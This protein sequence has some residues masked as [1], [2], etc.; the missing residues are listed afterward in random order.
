MAEQDLQDILELKAQR[1]IAEKE[2]RAFGLPE[3]AIRETLEEFYNIEELT[4]D[5]MFEDDF[6]KDDDF[7]NQESYTEAVSEKISHGIDREE[8][9]LQSNMEAIKA[10]GLQFAFDFASLEKTYRDNLE[11]HDLEEAQLSS[12]W[13]KLKRVADGL[14]MNRPVQTQE[15]N[16]DSLTLAESQQPPYLGILDPNPSKSLPIRKKLIRTQLKRIKADVKRKQALMDRANE[17]QAAARKVVRELFGDDLASRRAKR[18]ESN[19]RAMAIDAQELEEKLQKVQEM[20]ETSIAGWEPSRTLDQ[21]VRDLGIYVSQE[22]YDILPEE[23]IKEFGLVPMD[24][25]LLQDILDESTGSRK[26]VNPD[27]LPDG[28][29]VLAENKKGSVIPGVGLESQTIEDL[30]LTSLNL[31]IPVTPQDYKEK[32]LSAD[33]NIPRTSDEALDPEVISPFTEYYYKK[34][35]SVEKLFEHLNNTLKEDTKNGKKLNLAGVDFMRDLELLNSV[36]L[37]IE[38]ALSEYDASIGTIIND[39]FNAKYQASISYD[40][41]YNFAGVVLLSYDGPISKR[42][43]KR[44]PQIVTNL[45]LDE[46][47]FETDSALRNKNVLRYLQKFSLLEQAG[48]DNASQELNS[49]SSECFNSSLT[50][51]GKKLVSPLVEYLNFSKMFQEP[52]ISEPSSTELEKKKQRQDHVQ[53]VSGFKA[54]IENT[55]DKIN[56]AGFKA[57]RN[58][59]KGFSET[60]DSVNFGSMSEFDKK[61]TDAWM[62]F[63]KDIKFGGILEDGISQEDMLEFWTTAIYNPLLLKICP[64]EL[65]QRILECLMPSDCREIIKYIGIWRTRE[66]LENIAYLDVFDDRNGL[67]EALVKWDKLVAQKYNFKAV[68]FDGG[69]GLRSNHFDGKE[70][71]PSPSRMAVSLLVRTDL[72]HYLANE[73][74]K[75][76]IIT[77]TDTFAI[78]KSK[79]EELVFQITSPSG[80]IVEY[81]T[82]G[83]KMGTDN[84]VWDFLWHQIGFQWNGDAGLLTAYIDGVAVPTELTRGTPFMG[85]LNITETNSEFVIASSDAESANKSFAAQ[86]DE[87]VVFSKTLSQEQWLKLADITSDVNLNTMGMSDQTTDT[88]IWWRMGDSF[89]DTLKSNE[90]GGKI[91]D[92]ISGINLTKIP[93]NEE[94]SRVVV[95]RTVKQ[96]DEDDF[97]DI[98]ARDTDLLRL[99][100]LLY[101]S[102]AELLNTGFNVDEMIEKLQTRFQLPDFTKDPHQEVKIVIEKAVVFNLLKVVADYALAMIEKYLMDC[103]NWKELFKAMTKSTFNGTLAP[104]AESSAPLAQLLTSFD[105]PNFWSEFAQ[106]G[107]PFLQDATDALQQAV[108]ITS[109][110]GEGDD[111]KESAPVTLGIGSVSFQEEQTM[112]TELQDWSALGESSQITIQD[113]GRSDN[114]STAIEIIKKTSQNVS[115]AELLELLSSQGQESTVAKVSEI[116]NENFTD[117]TLS[118]SDIRTVFGI[119]GDALGV[120]GLIDQLAAAAENINIESDLPEEFCMPGQTFSDRVGFPTTRAD[121]QRNKDA[122]S[123]FLDKADNLKADL[124]NPCATPIP[125]SNFEQQALTNTIN[126]V[127]SSVTVAYDNDLLLYRLGMTSI[128]DKKEKIPKVL[129]KGEKIT[130]QVYDPDSGFSDREIEIKKTQINPDFEALIEQGILPLK[131][132]GTVDG[133]RFG[134]VVKINWN[135][136]DIFN[137]ETP[138]LSEKKPPE[139]LSP[140]VDGDNVKDPDV[141]IKDIGSSLGPYTDYEE[142]NATVSRPTAKLGG[143]MANSLSTDKL[144]FTLSDNE[145][146]TFYFSERSRLSERGYKDIVSKSKTSL[147]AAASKQEGGTDLSRDSFSTITHKVPYGK[148]LQG[149]KYVSFLKEG[150]DPFFFDDVPLEFNLS[151]NLQEEIKNR[152]YDDTEPACDPLDPTSDVELADSEKY[153]P[154][155]NVFAMVARQ[156]SSNLN[157]SDSVL[158][159]DAYNQLYREVLT[160]LLY[161][162]GDSPLLK[163]VPGTKDNTSE[164]LIG[165]NFLNI[166]VNP[167]LIDMQS[168]SEQVSNDFNQ[169]INCP[170]ALDEP[171]LYTALKTSV[172]RI[173]ARISVADMVLRGVIPFS[174]LF[175]SKRDPVIK[176]FIMKKLE[177]DIDLFADDVDGVKAK[178]VQ[179]YNKLAKTGE[180][181]DPAVSEDDYLETWKTAMNF[182]VEDEFDFVANRIKEIVHGK[183]IQP[184]DTPVEG[185]NE[186]MYRSI[187]T[188]A[189]NNSDNLN[190]KTIAVFNNGDEKETFSFKQQSQDIEKIISVLSFSFADQEIVL[191]KTEKTTDQIMND[192]D[193]DFDS[194]DCSQASVFPSSGQT[195]SAETHYHQ[196]EID[197]NGNGATTSVIGDHPDHV[198]AIYDYAVVPLLNESDETLHIHSLAPRLQQSSIEDQEVAMQVEEYLKV[199]LMGSSDFKILFDFS[200]N[201]NDAASLV[202]VYSLMAADNQIMSRAFNGTKRAAIQMFDWLWSTEPAANPCATKNGVGGMTNMGLPDMADAFMNP[203]YMLMLLLAPLLT[204]KGWTKVADPHVFI[205]TTI[206]DVLNSPINPKMVKKNIAD[207]FDNNKIKCMDMPTWPGTSPLDDLAM[208]APPA[209][210]G[211]TILVEPAVAGLVTIAPIP[212]TGSP[213]PPTPF[214]LI[215]YGLV[216]PIIWLLKDLPRLLAMMENDPEAQRLLASTGMNFGPITCDDDVPT[217]TDS[218]ST[219]GEEEDCPDIKTF[220]QTIIDAASAKCD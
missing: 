160:A 32:I 132:D 194:I 65:P 180:V 151:S 95:T 134:G 111:A 117:E 101:Q 142:L 131:K 139:S 67:L 46:A 205:T 6:F 58:T 192:L 53:S 156:N 96:E 140:K 145:S 22:E 193:L 10:A 168:F 104:L 85:P 103:Q 150:A 106:D 115:P 136:L 83:L 200:F 94:K 1:A 119:F 212:F 177:S 40:R 73:N 82:P 179:Q 31:L 152:G 164:P 60:V 91:V 87:I 129:W 183:C 155:E 21:M 102:T 215:Y 98:L 220:Q 214:G 172:P 54:T 107:V 216:S 133:T 39:G 135:I 109:T 167:R 217:R 112:G 33:M 80:D 114:R 141:E 66:F 174:E 88:K 149:T 100:D 64:A 144:G 206:M 162:V 9:E 37:E 213:F 196:Y 84:S 121:R 25:D 188:Y 201:L 186:D 204:F 143:E 127:Y 13:S 154:Q 97:I 26:I 62:E 89:E 158:K 209:T 163:A 42:A 166:N 110:A 175:F 218:G 52:S 24:M 14:P 207:P 195:T 208:L 108:K 178:I 190:F 138:F 157:L 68:E 197:S 128:T 170:D 126:D 184:E 15:Q 3:E 159:G 169:L 147:L 99:C 210:I 61:A 81:T 137:E 191:T 93:E 4:S 44:S 120:Q 19:E 219:E 38:N 198:H 55:V 122:V 76:Y 34:M 63:Q 57:K 124:D 48:K 49:F 123:D 69:T 125:L 146:P 20:V 23:Y 5:T 199:D 77:Q 171:P 153:T 75:K 51:N 182:F 59:E 118:R 70:L 56:E 173:L 86:L 47:L 2:L 17:L 116:V 130:R 29:D 105:D 148:S 12:M 7:D 35:E 50:L 72:E 161:K 187:L 79:K 16:N 28:A 71:F 30:Q 43:N 74:K 78:M 92:R 165:L 8:A 18:R 181:D 11:V 41:S 203:Q 27:E 202:L 176:S 36:P 185:I 189:Q 90:P 113:S 45:W 211:T